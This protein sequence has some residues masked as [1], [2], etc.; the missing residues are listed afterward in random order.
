MLRRFK[1]GLVEL[2]ILAAIIFAWDGALVVVGWLL[3]K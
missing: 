3:A 2:F 1:Q